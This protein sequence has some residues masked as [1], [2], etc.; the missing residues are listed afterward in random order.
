VELDA[1]EP[2]EGGT[3]CHVG[4]VEPLHQ[5]SGNWPCCSMADLVFNP[6]NGGEE[7]TL[8]DLRVT[9]SVLLEL[10]NGIQ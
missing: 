8:S 5:T 6:P 2:L 4:Q 7:P 10:S 1:E 3:T 9:I